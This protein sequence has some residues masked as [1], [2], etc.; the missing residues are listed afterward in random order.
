MSQA[1][2][3]LVETSNNMAIVKV[4]KGNFEVHNLMPQLS[5]YLQ[6][7]N[8]MENSS[9]I[10]SDGCKSYNDRRLSGL[11]TEYEFPDTEN[12]EQSL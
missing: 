7:I 11:E 2:K 3:G 9:C 6:G 1:M 10:P 8:C 4:I 5:Q 12:N